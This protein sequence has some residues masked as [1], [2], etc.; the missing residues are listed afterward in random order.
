MYYRLFMN[1]SVTLAVF[2]RVMILMRNIR[3][4]FGSP[5]LIFRR[6]KK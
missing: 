6:K 4:E 5:N 3:E 1:I 2:L